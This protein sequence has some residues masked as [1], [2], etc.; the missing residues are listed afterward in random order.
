MVMICYA[1]AYLLMRCLSLK[2]LQEA[3]Q[4]IGAREH[5]SVHTWIIAAYVE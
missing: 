5:T 3:S 1:A 4:C 2:H